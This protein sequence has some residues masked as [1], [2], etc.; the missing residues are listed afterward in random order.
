MVQEYPNTLKGLNYAQNVN[1]GMN[2]KLN[3]ME[4][5]FDDMPNGTHYK[6]KCPNCGNQN[7]TCHDGLCDKCHFTEPIKC[8]ACHSYVSQEFFNFEH[9]KCEEC[10][11]YDAQE[12]ASQ[13][14]NQFYNLN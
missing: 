4:N 1:S 13:L 10:V 5:W 6:G 3:N 12:F 7:Y 2:L 8:P 14:L 9:N 11:D